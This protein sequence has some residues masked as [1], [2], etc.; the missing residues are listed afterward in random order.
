MKG[1]K[2]KTQDEKDEKDTHE[3]K[4]N[5]HK[6][7]SQVENDTEQRREFRHKHMTERER[8]KR[9]QLRQGENTRGHAS[10][11]GKHTITAETQQR[12]F[13]SPSL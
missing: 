5:N 7:S 1:G 8:H 2:K 9:T 4:N 11:R 13:Y 10:I 3:K 12:D 6:T